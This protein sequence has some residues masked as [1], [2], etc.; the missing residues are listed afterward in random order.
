MTLFRWN[1]LHDME[2]WPSDSFGVQ[3]EINRVFDNFLHGC[4]RADETFQGSYYTPAVDIAE[5]DNEFIV[6]ME[7][8]GVSKEDVKISLESNI[9]TIKGEKKQEKEE[10]NKNFHRLERSYG[11]FQRSFT[12]PTTVK[13]DKIDAVFTD[14]VLSVTLPR[15]EESK[16]KQIEVKVK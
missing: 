7:L 1:Q 13:S 10:E 14:G 2:R 5:H 9:L 8:A 4:A 6:K 3:S 11:S 16:P 15:M 12:L